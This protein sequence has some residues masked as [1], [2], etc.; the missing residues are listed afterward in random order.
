MTPKLKILYLLLKSIMMD[1]SATNNLMQLLDID[2]GSLRRKCR[3][4]TVGRIEDKLL[5]TSPP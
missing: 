4:E 1:A 3:R 5:H 2:K